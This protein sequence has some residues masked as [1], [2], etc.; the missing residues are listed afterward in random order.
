MLGWS[1]IAR[2]CRSA[3]KRAITC[4]VSM[5]GLMIFSATRRSTGSFLLGHVDHAHAP[6]ADL[7]Q[8]LVGADLRAGLFEGGLV[9]RGKEGVGGC[10]HDAA[11]A[12]VGLQQTFHLPPQLR[13]AVASAVQVGLPLVRRL[14]LNRCTENRVHA[15]FFA[16]RSTPDLTFQ[17]PM[18]RNGSGRPRRFQ[19]FLAGR[20]L[21]RRVSEK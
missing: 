15:R 19:E 17:L 1:I 14:D 4:R 21:Y 5:P 16:H 20:Y 7:L 12:V 8:Q 3:S 13:I 18:R 2:A 6:F 9:E 11:P 10:V